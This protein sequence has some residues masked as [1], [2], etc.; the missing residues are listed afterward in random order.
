MIPCR[1]IGRFVPFS[2]SASLVIVLVVGLLIGPGGAAIAAGA[3]EGDEAADYSVVQGDECVPV[4]PLGDGSQSV[5]EFYDYRTPNTEPSSHTYSSYGTTHLQEDD[6]SGFFLYDGRDGLS[7][8][9]VH[10]RYDGNSPGGAVTM[11]FDGLPADGEWVVE[12]DNY[13][14]DL[15]PGPFDE[16]DHDGTSS[17]ITWVYTDNRT[18]GAAFRGGL[19]DEFAIEIEPSFD[20]AADFQLYEGEL[21][22]WEVI[23][24]TEDGY[25]R[26]SIEMDDSAV[27]QSGGCTSMAVTDLDVPETAT[28]GESI[29]VE[30]LVENEGHEAGT[31]AVPVT[32]DGEQVDERDV[33]LD[34][35][36]T[37]TVATS[38]TFDEPGTYTVGVGDATVDVTV[39]T[40]DRIDDVYG[41]GVTAAVVSTAILL[42]AIGVR[43]RRR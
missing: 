12:D 15:G 3:Q 43:S 13:S 5:E 40:G 10:D 38:V 17:R 33:T 22:A 7:L 36:E 23:S 35:G 6:T 16:F 37:T 27:L 21:T 18:D 41:F 2:L 34:P 39:T 1:I 19:D 4:E 32:I 20:E 24:A 26:T 29:D 11:Q 9:L 8:V 14:E 25:E 31:S 42:L 28:A 30:A